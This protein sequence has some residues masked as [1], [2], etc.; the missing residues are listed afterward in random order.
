MKRKAV[1]NGVCLI[2]TLVFEHNTRSPKKNTHPH[3]R[4]SF[5]NLSGPLQFSKVT[6]SFKQ[7]KP[8]SKYCKV[9]SLEESL[10]KAFS[11]EI[12]IFQSK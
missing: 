4:E 5:H 9:I 10:N 7:S 2:R 8:S 11:I 3:R 1:R 6:F 12:L